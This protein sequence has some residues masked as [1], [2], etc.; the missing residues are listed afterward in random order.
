MHDEALP[1]DGDF[2]IMKHPGAHRGRLRFCGGLALFSQL[3]SLPASRS[4]ACTLW[5]SQR[6]TVALEG[7]GSTFLLLDLRGIAWRKIFQTAPEP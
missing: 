2:V 6:K 5:D 4:A 3:V 1:E 7:P